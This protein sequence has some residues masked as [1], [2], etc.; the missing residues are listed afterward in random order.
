MNEKETTEIEKRGVGSPAESQLLTTELLGSTVFNPEVFESLYRIAQTLAKSSL[1]PETLRGK[2]KGGKLVEEHPPEKV[3]ANCFLVVEQA[4]RWQMSPFAVIAHASV[5]YGRLMWEGKLVHAVIEQKLGVRLHYDFNGEK[6]DALGVTVSGTL[7]GEG[8]PRTLF[9]TVGQ[10]KTT[11]DGSPWSNSLNH[12]RQLRYR[13]AREWARAFAPGVMMGVITEDEAVDFGKMKNV[14]EHPVRTEIVDPFKPRLTGSQPEEHS[15]SSGKEQKQ[16]EGPESKTASQG[17]GEKML[18]AV[19]SEVEER[20]FKKNDGTKG[21]YYL[22][23]LF[24]EGQAM[25]AGTFSKTVADKAYSLKGAEVLV[26]LNH[27]DKGTKLVSIKD[28][29]EGGIV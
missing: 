6:G 24:V 22:A 9:G 8:E 26:E 13:G 2:M 28:A 11:G 14:T 7:P 18:P 27:T 20:A 17:E 4:H 25:R 29:M 3:A 21:I 5:V 23:E 10:W 16:P 15:Q 19:L 1:I 12:P